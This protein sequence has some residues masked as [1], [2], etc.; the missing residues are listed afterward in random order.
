MLEKAFFPIRLDSD[1][2]HNEELYK[3]LC[4]FSGTL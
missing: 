1:K 4:P 2:Q 3:Q